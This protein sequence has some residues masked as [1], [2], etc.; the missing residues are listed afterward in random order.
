MV[1]GNGIVFADWLIGKHRDD[2]S[3]FGEDGLIEAA[4]PM[5]GV[6][7]P[8]SCFE[9]GASDGRELSNTL[10]L[11]E[12]GWRATLIE[13]KHALFAKQRHW[14]N[15]KVRTVHAFVTPGNVNQLITGGYD[16]GVIDIDGQD[17]W[18]WQAMDIYP[19]LM[20]VE[21]CPDESQPIP[22]L[23]S[24]TG[25]APFE[26]IAHLGQERG[27]DLLARTE[28]NCLFAAKEA[29]LPG[30]VIRQPTIVFG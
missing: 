2:Y 6:T 11:R 13:S 16:F 21:Y 19:A 25:Q 17:Y 1:T 30:T 14:A 12:K 28:V 29:L 9:F 10:T 15:P 26:A 7:G 20:L 22:E 18:V 27:Y 8:G 23:G 24:L 3:Q 4:L 5:V